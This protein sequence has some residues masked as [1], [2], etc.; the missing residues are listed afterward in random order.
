MV[1]EDLS[2]QKDE[3]PEDRSLIIVDDDRAFLV[4]DK[5]ARKRHVKRHQLGFPVKS[6]VFRPQHGAVRADGKAGFL[7]LIEMNRIERIALR[8]RVLPRPAERVSFLRKCKVR[9]A[10]K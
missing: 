4:T 8:Q 5:N 7:V 3:L 10:Q 1:T 9:S 6:A 2:F